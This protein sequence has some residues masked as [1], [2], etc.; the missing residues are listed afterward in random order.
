MFFFFIYTELIIHQ[1]KLTEVA[2]NFWLRWSIMWN[3]GMLRDCDWEPLQHKACQH[4][5]TSTLLTDHRADSEQ[6][7]TPGQHQKNYAETLG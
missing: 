7:G 1:R 5:T 6:A 2:I 3:C 4:N